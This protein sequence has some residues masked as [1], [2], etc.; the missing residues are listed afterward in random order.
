MGAARPTGWATL[1]GSGSQSLAQQ[2]GEALPS[3]TA[4]APLGPVFGRV[5]HQD[6]A[7]QASVEPTEDA[8]SLCLR[9]GTRRGDVD[10]E[11]DTG[12]GR[13]DALAA[14][15]TGAREAFREIGARDDEPPGHAGA[16]WYA[17]FAHLFR[18]SPSPR[19]VHGRDLWVPVT[20]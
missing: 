20:P 15:A 13:V 2:V 18:V 12:V 9:Q 7:G 19:G 16:G 10:G 3:S 11:L 17:Q 5:D 4:I 8:L 14:G 6:G 1:R